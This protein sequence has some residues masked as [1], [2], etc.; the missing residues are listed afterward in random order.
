MHERRAEASVAISE[1]IDAP[2]VEQ[3]SGS[4]GATQIRA[5]ILTQILRGDSDRQPLGEEPGIARR[6]D[7]VRVGQGP[8]GP[9]G[10]K[11]GR[12]FEIGPEVGEPDRELAPQGIEGT[13]IADLSDVDSGRP[14]GVAEMHVR[15]SSRSEAFGVIPAQDSG[16]IEEGRGGASRQ[17]VVRASQR[18]PARV[19][20]DLEKRPARGRS[21]LIPELRIERSSTHDRQ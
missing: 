19:D 18:R 13:R 16:G 14:R 17:G 10:M 12:L 8:T 5:E 3:D 6:R 15:V 1:L 7:E 9:S 11:L 2:R 20:P 21:P 4:D